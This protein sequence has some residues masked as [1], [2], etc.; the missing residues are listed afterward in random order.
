M[1]RWKKPNSEQWKINKNK[2]KRR[3]GFPYKS[4][5]KK[6]MPTKAPKLVDCSTCF[7]KC[8]NNFSQ[9]DRKMICA[10]Y[11]SGNFDKQRNLILSLVD[12]KPIARK[13]KVTDDGKID[14]KS[15]Y[16][17]NLV[18]TIT[19]SGCAKISFIRHYVSVIDP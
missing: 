19:K 3:S 12:Q 17:Y 4:K 9:D 1:T 8:S 7:Y 14:K 15:S 10:E 13:R 11:T 18:K 16:S 5:T 6:D 2:A